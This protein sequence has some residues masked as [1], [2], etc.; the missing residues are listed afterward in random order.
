MLTL[1]SPRQ[2]PDV[3]LGTVDAVV[4]SD[5]NL[6]FLSA[7]DGSVPL[8]GKHA[9][10]LYYHD[11]R[12]LD[13]YEL[14]VGGVKPEG[15]VA[16]A[17]STYMAT[18]E[19]TNPDFISVTGKPIEKQRIGIKWERIIEAAKLGL[20][21]RITFRNFGIEPIALAI[22]L[23]FQAGFQDIFSIRG[24]KNKK[25]GKL[26]APTWDNGVLR[27]LYK[28]VDKIY[29]GAAIHFSPAVEPVGNG[30]GQLQ[31]KLRPGESKQL[32][33][34]AMI[35]ESAEEA[36]A[37]PHGYVASDFDALVS[38]LHRKVREW[39]AEHTEIKSD[40]PLLNA[41]MRRSLRDHRVLKSTSH[42]HHYF[43]AGLP[44]FCALFGRD[45]LIASIEMLAYAPHIAEQ[46]LWLLARYQGR[47]LDPSHDEEPGKIH[48]E[49]RVGELAN[50]KQIL[51]T[52]YYGTVDATA[53]FLILVGY[54]A[55]WT[56]DL[57][58]FQQLRGNVEG[59]LE[60][61]SKYG[62]LEGNGYVAYQS[63][64][65]K[66]G[67]ANQGW[68]DS[69]DGIV[70]EDGSLAEP[71]IA[72]VEVQGY[73]YLAKTY[74]AD[75][76]RRTGEQERADQLLEE[77]AK[78]RSHFN[79]DFWMEDKKFYALA[80]QRDRKPTAVISSNPGQALWSGI[81]DPNKA[82][83]VAD[84]LM[85]EDMFNGWGI[86]TLS[87]RERSYN[88]VGY[89]LGTVW[90]HDN[91]IIAIGLRKYGLDD[92]FLR[93][94][95]GMVEAASHF[96]HYRLPELFAGFARKDYGVPVPYPEACQPQIWA[97][98]AVP[99]MLQTALGLVPLGFERRL[100]VVRPLLPEFVQHLEVHRLKVA[101]ASVSLGFERISDRAVAVKVLDVDGDL[102]VSVEPE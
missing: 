23:T 90:P 55:A 80:L 61:L 60:W 97:A 10:G 88:P 95:S 20:L 45:S 43:A 56:G 73:V 76:Y 36:R 79:Q 68:K 4:L 33:V 28:G 52:P 35:S 29:R 24:V 77:A 3:R 40:S 32:R 96:E 89:H 85:G 99:M 7:R 11:T 46:T 5:E 86:R 100:R 101:N 17:E 59:A 16:A 44:W 66:G 92:L 71:P 42:K 25:T 22:S 53:L 39:E 51:Q 65:K 6:Y 82:K 84:R 78:L 8:G 26:R 70:N 87:E 98:G 49:L 75:L 15:L 81:V 21:D 48:H 30:G 27:F 69:G 50:S 63:K 37:T 102:E 74:L 2:H 83:L 13:G 38:E 18:L 57:T 58:L 12:F 14:L 19:L 9:L 91:A 31:M 93:V 1:K 64:A 41:V 67:L 72:L 94:F 47:Q 62:D 54:H 34:S